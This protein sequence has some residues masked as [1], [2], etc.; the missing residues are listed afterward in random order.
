MQ[1][2]TS[3]QWI[4]ECQF[5]FFFFTVNEEVYLQIAGI[6]EKWR[7]Q[8]SLITYGYSAGADTEVQAASILCVQNLMHRQDLMVVMGGEG[9]I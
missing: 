2:R 1:S 3:L 4:R 8:I 9:D 7:N 5:S 6:S